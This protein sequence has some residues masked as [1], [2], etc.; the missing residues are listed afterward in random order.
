[1][2]TNSTVG[3]HQPP[4]PSSHLWP[5]RSLYLD[6]R[7]GGGRGVMILPC[8]DAMA[9]LQH[10]DNR[11]SA[12]LS[13]RPNVSSFPLTHLFPN[14]FWPLFARSL[15]FSIENLT[16]I[17]GLN[18]LVRSSI[19]PVS[20]CFYVNSGCLHQLRSDHKGGSIVLKMSSSGVGSVEGEPP[21]KR[22]RK[23]T[24]SCWECKAAS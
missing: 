24:R 18:P 4:Q 22:V 20:L 16:N 5:M 14:D 2:L 1:M 8:R 23:G 11:I 12:L 21:R 15:R 9:R 17:L 7:S 6:R 10:A 13:P 19:R 3:S